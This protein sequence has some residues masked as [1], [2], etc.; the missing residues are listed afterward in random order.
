MSNDCWWN[1]NWGLFLTH[2]WD[3]VVWTAPLILSLTGIWTQVLEIGAHYLLNHFYDY[4]NLTI[5][6]LFLIILCNNIN[7][8]YTSTMK[9]L[10][11]SLNSCRDHIINLDK[12][13]RWQ[14]KSGWCDPVIDVCIDVYVYKLAWIYIYIYVCVCVCV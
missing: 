12:T 7:N 6:I 2:T 3:I 4:Y 5:I 13:R 8:I 1:N 10:I 11:D 14:I 9:W